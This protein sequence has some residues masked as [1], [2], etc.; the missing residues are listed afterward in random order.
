MDCP[1]CSATLVTTTHEGLDIAAC[2]NG[3]GMFLP[4]DTLLAAVRSRSEDRAEHDENI[5]LA[6][7]KPVSPATEQARTC[8]ACGATMNKLTYAYESGVLIDT[9]AAH[10]VWLDNGELK[11]I[12][13]WVE[14]SERVAAGEA[15][16]WHARLDIVEMESDHEA[17]RA[18][19]SVHFGPVGKLT[20]S[21]SRWWL[22]RDDAERAN[23]QR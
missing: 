13:A 17:A 15:A 16:S 14:G 5:A 9:C 4:G 23:G 18:S 11:R 20:R 21:L 12:E 1:T 7:A 22:Q 2:P 19:G 6:T 10:G 3:D 8:P